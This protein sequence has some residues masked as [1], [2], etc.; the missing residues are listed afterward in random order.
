VV[1]A[2]VLA[3]VVSACAACRPAAPVDIGHVGSTLVVRPA[4]PR[5]GRPGSPSAVLAG[6]VYAKVTLEHSLA[7]PGGTALVYTYSRL[8][9]R[10]GERRA[11]GHDVAA[12]LA[13]EQRH[14][15]DERAALD[16]VAREQL[17]RDQPSCKALAGAALL[18]DAQL[19]PRCRAVGVAYFDA[20]GVL[21][22]D[23]PIGGAC[24][25]RVLSF[26]AYD[27]TP[28]PT[29]ELLLLATFETFGEREQGGLGTTEEVTRMLVLGLVPDPQARLVQQLDLD[30]AV[31]REGVSCR[32]GT[33]RSLRVASPGRL[34][35][36]SQDWNDCDREHCMDPLTAAE[37]LEDEDPAVLPVCEGEPVS[38]AVTTWSPAG[39]A[40]SLLEPM[41]YQGTV[42]PDG[43]MR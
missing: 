4:G 35:V 40:W 16:P 21:R 29:D 43:L 37:M 41:P 2:I 19:V 33:Q 12:E 28:E 6:Q 18:D 1:R 38:A 10:L 11:A 13:A 7:V 14:C 32:T 34:E 9:S 39:K 27:L 36:F 42:L 26:E 24:L 17:Q 25:G 20:A 8:A 5:S 22:G 3:S 30:L 15:E 23:V 31:A